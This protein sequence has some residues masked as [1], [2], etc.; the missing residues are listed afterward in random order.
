MSIEEA[1]EILWPKFADLT[2][3]EITDIVSLYRAVSRIFIKK[4]IANRKS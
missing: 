4:H 1:R 3:E 2:D